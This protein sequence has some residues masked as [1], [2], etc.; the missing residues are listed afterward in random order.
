M[1]YV[2]I[3]TSPVD[4]EYLLCITPHCDCLRPD[5][6][7]NGFYFVIGTEINLPTG[8]KKGDTGFISYIKTEKGIICIEWKKSPFTIYIPDNNISNPIECDFS[9]KKIALKYLTCQ[10]ENYTQRIANESFSSA[11]RVGINLAKFG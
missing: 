5:K 11:S 8:L 6:I 4:N 10:K 9:G 7:N 1:A 3:A 2:D